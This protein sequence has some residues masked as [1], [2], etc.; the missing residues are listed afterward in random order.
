MAGVELVGTLEKAEE[1]GWGYGTHVIDVNGE[2]FALTSDAV[3]LDEYAGQE[4][5][6]FGE[7]VE[8]YPTGGQGP[9]YLAVTEVGTA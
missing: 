9:L 8:G 4:V 3:D 2:V 6:L 7:S 5:K 1:P